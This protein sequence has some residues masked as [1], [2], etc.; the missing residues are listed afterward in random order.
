MNDKRKQY[1]EKN[2]QKIQNYRKEYYEKNKEIEKEYQKSLPKKILTDEE[3]E[4][5]RLYAIEYRKRNKDRI[6]IARDKW[7][8]KNIEKI[9]EY[10]RK[11][12]CVD[13]LYKLIKNIRTRISN[14]F[15]NEGYSKSSKTQDILGCSF[16]EFKLHLESQFEDW[17]TWDNYGNPK[18]G[19]FEY[20]KTWDI[21]HIIP[22]ST[23]KTEEDIIKLNHHTN[24]QPLCSK[25]NRID[26]RND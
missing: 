4:K 5:R 1:R 13:E 10:S 26:K 12:S 17:M 14:S 22:I 18:D 21:D 3:K 6:K 25:F 24:L 9:N 2:K 11:R 20:N 15:R 23:A 16:D 8:N 19:I 7:K